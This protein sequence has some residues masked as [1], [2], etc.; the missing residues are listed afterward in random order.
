ML[1]EVPMKGPFPET[2][3]FI[4]DYGVVLKIE[5]HIQL[6]RHE[7]KEC[8]KKQGARM[9][10][11]AVNRQGIE[12]TKG[13]QNDKTQIQYTPLTERDMMVL[14]RAAATRP[15]ISRVEVCQATIP[16]EALLGLDYMNLFITFV[17]GDNSRTWRGHLWEDIVNIS[18]N[19]STPWGVMSDFNSVLHPNERLGVIQLKR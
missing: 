13:N 7:E 14:M 4:N 9:E 1:I 12:P 17:C 5:D 16:F 18:M 6:F 3:E 2:I 15:S 8:R 11:R 10:W 19:M